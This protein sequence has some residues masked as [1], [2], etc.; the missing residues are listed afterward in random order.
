M[1]SISTPTPSKN[2]DKML[3]YA[4]VISHNKGKLAGN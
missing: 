3:P 4:L 2:I 1:L